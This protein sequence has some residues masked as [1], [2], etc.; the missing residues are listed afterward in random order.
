MRGLGKYQWKILQDLVKQFFVSFYLHNNY[1]KYLV[2]HCFPSIYLHYFFRY[3]IWLFNI[4]MGNGPFIDGLPIS[5][6][7][8]S[9]A[10]C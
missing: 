9:M 7:D 5:M 8:L 2:N 4:A 1:M 10:N 6:V 3:T